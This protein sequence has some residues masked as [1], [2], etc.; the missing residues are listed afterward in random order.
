MDH[1]LA[2]PWARRLEILKELASAVRTDVENALDGLPVGCELGDVVG[3]SVASIGYELDDTVNG[4][5]VGS[6]LGELLDCSA[7]TE[8]TLPAHVW[9]AQRKM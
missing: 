4:L 8:G 1:L 6:R 7:V 3:A 2:L 5:S 9:A